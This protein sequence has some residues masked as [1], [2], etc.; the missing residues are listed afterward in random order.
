MYRRRLGQIKSF[1][2]LE[3]MNRGE[4]DNQ[5]HLHSIGG[6]MFEDDD[7]YDEH[8]SKRRVISS[9][10]YENS[11]GEKLT[12]PELQRKFP[13]MCQV[14]DAHELR[15]KFE[16]VIRN[17]PPTLPDPT[18][19]KFQGWI[20]GLNQLDEIKQKGHRIDLTAPFKMVI[21]PSY[22][23]QSMN[24]RITCI[25]RRNL[26]NEINIMDFIQ[27]NMPEDL[28]IDTDHDSKAHNK[29]HFKFL[30]TAYIERYSNIIQ[31][32]RI[33]HFFT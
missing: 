15:L 2:R 22:L 33:G 7:E 31:I 5:Y 8:D 14:N 20:K 11:E 1:S 32:F 17:A 25:F 13:G 19:A 9:K 21:H 27:G 26:V 29:L 10:V 18:I 30:E 4:F 23:L 16:D 28:K 6:V 24:N 12:W 3:W